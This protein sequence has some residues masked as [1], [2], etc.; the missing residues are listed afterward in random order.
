[1]RQLLSLFLLAAILGPPLGMALCE[2][3]DS[4]PAWVCSMHDNAES[5]AR[6]CAARQGK[7]PAQETSCHGGRTR[8]FI[9]VACH[10][11]KL[12]IVP[13]LFEVATLPSKTQLFPP[14]GSA[15]LSVSLRSGSS[16]SCEPLEL[17]PRLAASPICSC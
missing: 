1:M 16:R 10:P 6:A 7:E 5:C 3:Q 12:F 8:C 2:A 15:D 17:P 11:A 4:E 13:F 14:W 9:S